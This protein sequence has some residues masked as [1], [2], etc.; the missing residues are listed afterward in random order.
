MVNRFRLPYIEEL[1][2]DSSKL[3]EPTPHL[4]YAI[5]TATSLKKITIRVEAAHMDNWS[6]A[7]LT[8][9]ISANR[10]VSKFGVIG[11]DLPPDKFSQLMTIADKILNNNRRIT[12]FSISEGKL[13]AE[14]VKRVDQTLTSATWL[15][16]LTIDVSS[17]HIDIYDTI[18]RFTHLKS[19]TMS[20][21]EGPDPQEAH[22]AAQALS[23]I[24]K[25]TLKGDDMIR[26]LF[27]NLSIDSLTELHVKPKHDTYGLEN[28]AEH[29][30]KNRTLTAFTLNRC[31]K[32]TRKFRGLILRH[33][34][35]QN[36]RKLNFALTP[37]SVQDL[38]A[39]IDS[40]KTNK[41]ITSISFVLHNDCANQLVELLAENSTLIHLGLT[42][43]ETSDDTDQQIRLALAKNKTLR[44]LHVISS[45]LN[46]KIIRRSNLSTF[47]ITNA[48][49]FS[50]DQQ[51]QF[52]LD[53]NEVLQKNKALDAVIIKENDK[54]LEV[55]RKTAEMLRTNYRRKKRRKQNIETFIRSMA[56]RPH[57]YLSLLPLEI[58]SN[59]LKR[60]SFP[61]VY[62]D[63]AE[64]LLELFSSSVE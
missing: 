46:A 5:Q 49:E 64:L 58:W 6:C 21:Q 63:F 41:L 52:W 56:A 9:A 1:D 12:N 62:V 25:L 22:I 2:L 26:F 19:L 42:L 44:S 51:E 23:R 57:V 3:Q 40:L 28:L 14:K 16:H 27:H 10:S 54:L 55:D 18:K 53:M 48:N 4:S 29:V 43:P 59:I 32:K 37:F 36:L 50:L 35:H 17:Q 13:S 8:D 34:L 45:N 47:K 38:T 24:S 31:V 15:K 7:W 30:K 33:N 11:P 60:I 61:G 20:T 39:I